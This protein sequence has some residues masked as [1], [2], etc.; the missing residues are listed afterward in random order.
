MVRF[1]CRWFLVEFLPYEEADS[2][3]SV[4]DRPPLTTNDIRDEIRDSVLQN[5]GEH[6]WGSVGDSLNVK[7][8]SPTTNIC[9]IR[10]AR[11]P[12]RIAWGGITFIT[13]IKKQRCIPH[14]EHVSGTLKKVQLAAIQYNRVL[15]ARL[16]AR[17]ELGDRRKHE[18][19]EYLKQ[20]DKEIESI[21]T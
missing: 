2:K 21:D 14:V 20:A 13:A 4:D 3:A 12:Y 1:K 8:Y 6:G 11:E 10:V 7:Y 18:L 19:E 9:I 17:A 16:E 5:F 15:V